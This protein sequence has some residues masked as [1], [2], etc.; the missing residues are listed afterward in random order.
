[1]RLCCFAQ[2]SRTQILAFLVSLLFLSSS[3]A[4]ESTIPLGGKW[5]FELD[6]SDAGINSRWFDRRLPGTIRLPGSLPEQGIGDDISL[7]TPW[8][9]GIV[10][11]SFFQAPEYAKYRQPG[12]IKVPFWLQPEKYYAGVAWFQREITIPKRWA[13][14]RVVLFL[15]RPHWE[16]RV[17][18]DGQLIGANQSLSTPHQYDLG[19]L[20]IGNHRLSIRVDNRLIVDVGRDSH[21]VSDH[22]QGNWNGIVGKVE[23]RATPPVWLDDLQLFPDFGRRLVTIRGHLGNSTREP[24]AGSITF[25]IKPVERLPRTKPLADRT[26]AQVNWKTEGGRFE[27]E[28]AVPGGEAW[29]EFH[30]ALYELTATLDSGRGSRDTRSV[31]FGFRDLSTRGTQFTING[32][33]LFIRGTLECCIFP[34]TGHPPAD[35]ESWVRI[36]RIAKAHG[37]NNL[38]FHSWCPPEAAFS[39]ADEAGMY[40]HVECASWANAS[41]TLGDGKPV[42]RWIYQEADRILEWYGNHPSF[43]LML[44]GNEPG[45]ERHKAFLSKWVTHYREADPRRLYSSGAG[46]PQLPENQFHVVPDPR[47][48]AWGAG[49]K[50]RIN[51]MP[52]E[53]MADY[54]E[55]VAARKV[56]VIS[57]EIGQ[58]CV[59]PNFEETTQYSGYLKPRNFEIFRETLASHGMLQL[60]RPFLLASGKLQAL[61]YKEEIESALRTPGMG[62]FQLLDLHDF[63]GQGTALI[64]VL[65]PFWNEKGYITAGQFHRF[66]GPTVPLARLSKRTFT[67]DEQTAIA[68]DL[69]QY[70]DTRL[71]GAWVILKVTDP[72][73]K[74]HARV[75]AKCPPVAPGSLQRVLEV[76]QDFKT[77]AA[78]AQYKVVTEIARTA[79]GAGTICENDWDIWVYPPARSD[80][81][82]EGVTIVRELNDE[83]AAA[84]AQG[85]KVLWLLPPASVAPDPKLGRIELGF[86]SVFWNTAWTRRQA[87][88]TLGILC[89]PKHPLF[90]SFPTEFHT[91]W[92]WWDLL[93]QAAPM[94]VG[95]LPSSLTP[96][97][98]V[99][100]DWFTARKLALVFEAKVGPGRLLVCSIDLEHNLD[101]SPVLRQFRQSLLEYMASSRFAPK[102][103][104]SIEQ[105][106]SLRQAG[107]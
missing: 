27:T 98:R 96:N 58:W 88:H 79:E 101:T 85:S 82:V 1:M 34:K 104:V 75:A 100:D 8:T 44:Y 29:D 45:G 26:V 7:E 89:D 36:F 106:R 41:T 53:T 64:G 65:D 92:Q 50:S 16:T 40:L 107:L 3:L 81:A 35:R 38:R 86:S 54:R 42:D 94:L 12:N 15:E 5:T 90:S 28:M 43:A 37:L 102:A 51:A 56:P 4:G 83:A 14:Q 59:Y 22:T 33:P 63:P 31:Q 10:D 47:I 103:G 99:I 24:G 20:A 48:Q 93:H 46:W 23:L 17:W 77:L 84:L 21:S 32:R 39:A 97:V 74:T 18:L 55:Y 80:R 95:E 87:P 6:R 78:P 68:I 91:N 11:R 66:C 62:G 73:G 61:C 9:G 30:P 49:L 2:A 72:Y 13:G 52:P 69:A 67:Q 105:L 19:R 25:L 70:G 57:H 76:K 71:D 60:A